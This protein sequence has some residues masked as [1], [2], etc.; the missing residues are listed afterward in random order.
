M[1]VDS[2][3]SPVYQVEGLPDLVDKGKYYAEH[4]KLCGPSIGSQSLNSKFN[5][6]IGSVLV[7]LCKWNSTTFLPLVVEVRVVQIHCGV[8]RQ[9]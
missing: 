8:C 5:V 7:R 2:S 9:L 1:G 4:D 3:L 6:R